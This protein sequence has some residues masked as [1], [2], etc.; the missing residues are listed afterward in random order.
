M[1]AG[2]PVAPSVVRVLAP[3]P[4]PMTLTGTNTYL[5]GRLACIVVD[6]GPDIPEHLDAIIRA[7]AR[8]GRI[9][10]SCVTHHHGDHLP[11]ALSLRRR[12]GTP[13]AGHRELPNV[14][15]PLADGEVVAIGGVRLRAVATPGHTPDHLCYVL[16]DDGVLFTG[17]LIAGA[18]TVIVGDGRGELAEYMASLRRVAA[19]EP[20]HLLP[21]HGPPV[22][23]AG[24][25]ID[26]YLEHRLL[27]ERQIV[28]ALGAGPATVRQVVERV[29]PELPAALVEMAARNVRAHL[30]KLEDD[31]RVAS[32]GQAWQI[33][34]GQ[35]SG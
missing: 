24:A 19:L 14:D 20:R 11:A 12:L 25:K 10:L 8:L 3:N 33:L 4:S 34:S 35:V 1:V 29:Y 15:R 6:P 16:E 26:E 7:A 31:G 9:A 13:I 32:R 17:D 30:G 28:D 21:G 22:D 27:R 18:G 23:D 5:V 2:E